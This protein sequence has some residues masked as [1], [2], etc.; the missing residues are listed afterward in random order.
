MLVLD[1]VDQLKT[2]DRTAI[3]DAV[4]AATSE[5]NKW[6]ATFNGEN[7]MVDENGHNASATPIVLQWQNGLPTCVYP[8]ASANSPIVDPNTLQPYQ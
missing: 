4:F 8:V 6:M 3:R 2:T 5:S 7:N 1:L